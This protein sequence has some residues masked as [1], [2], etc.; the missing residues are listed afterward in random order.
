MDKLI[1]DYKGGS[2]APP[3][4]TTAPTIMRFLDIVHLAA[5]ILVDIARSQDSEVS[6][7]KEICSNLLEGALGLL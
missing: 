6:S 2:T 5:K 7:L 1:H 3:S 4:P